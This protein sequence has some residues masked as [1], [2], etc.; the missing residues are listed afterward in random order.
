[1]FVYFL[2]FIVIGSFIGKYIPSPQKGFIL[3]ILI[4]LLWSFASKPLWG[5]VA[6]GELLFG[7]LF[8]QYFLSERSNK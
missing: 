4:A 2:I 3:C 5:L 7:F 1:M 6:L 8:H